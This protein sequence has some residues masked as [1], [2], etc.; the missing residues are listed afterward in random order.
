MGKPF[1]FKRIGL[2]ILVAGLIY[3]AILHYLMIKHGNETPEAGA[4]YI[5]ILG[6]RVKGDV[7][8]LALDARIEAAAGYL[9]Q[10][11]KTVAI[12]SGGQGRGENISEAVS[13]RE[14][15]SKRGIEKERILIEDKSTSTYENINFSKKLIPEGA[16][17]GLVVTN[18]FHVYRAKMIARDYG[19]TVEGLPAETPVQA[20]VKS[21]AREY[22][23]ITKYYLTK[24]F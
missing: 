19:L 8:S 2:F 24:V 7:P 13:I 1:L 16:T 21:Y 11:P 4:D 9:R 12:A 17:K 5:I 20:L 15:L 22:L 14:E 23:A 10:N 6:A 3:V 18:D